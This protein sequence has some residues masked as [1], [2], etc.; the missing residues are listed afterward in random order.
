MGGWSLLKFWF[1]LRTV[2]VEFVVNEV[3][4]ACHIIPPAGHTHTLSAVSWKPATKKVTVP[5]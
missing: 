4:L 5:A 3:A 2:H 1:I